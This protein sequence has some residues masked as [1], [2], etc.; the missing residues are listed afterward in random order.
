MLHTAITD[1]L[2]C[3]RSIEEQKMLLVIL[4]KTKKPVK[5]SAVFFEL[6]SVTFLN[7]GV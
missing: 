2:W 5:M 4:M 1:S 6:T 3:D 7:V